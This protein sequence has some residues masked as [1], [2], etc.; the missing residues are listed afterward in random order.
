[1]PVLSSS[2]T[3]TLA[4]VATLVLGTLALSLSPGAEEHTATT[5]CHTLPLPLFTASASPS[6]GL[7]LSAK[8]LLYCVAASSASVG[9][10][11]EP[12][13]PMCCVRMSVCT[14]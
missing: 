10:L 9:R 5:A 14:V 7:L 6:S 1:M 3:T 11:E 4:N 13:T 2:T 12:V 8:C